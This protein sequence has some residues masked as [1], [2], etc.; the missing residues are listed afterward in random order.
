MWVYIWKEEQEWQ[1]GEN[2]LLYME[3][4]WDLSDSSGNSNQ[5]TWSW[6]DYETIGSKKCVKLTSISGWISWPWNLMAS[7]WTGDFATAF[8]FYPVG[9]SDWPVMFANAQSSSPRSWCQMF[10]C[11]DSRWSLNNQVSYHMTQVW[12]W[13]SMSATSLN[14]SWHHF[15]F[16]RIS[17][18]CYWYID[19]QEAFT[20]WAD[21]SNLSWVNSLYILNRSNQSDQQR[22]NPWAKMSELIVESAW[23]TAQEISDYYNLTKSNYW[24]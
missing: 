13:S 1:P 17:G 14:N 9:S 16:T 21:N 18:I 19:W 3:F 22:D 7:V 15:V 10:I 23:W 12:H 5:M 6:I 4:N 8:W 20:S 24:L 11:Y 2:T